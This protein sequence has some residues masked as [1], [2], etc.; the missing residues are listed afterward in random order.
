MAM[1]TNFTIHPT[2]S[3]K[4]A[5]LRLDKNKHGIILIISKSSKLIGVATDG[6]IRRKLVSDCKISDAIKN[7]MNTDFVSVNLTT[8]RESVIKKFD[9]NIKVIPV[10]NSKGILQKIYTLNDFPVA[11]EKSNYSRAKAPVRISFGGGGSD[12]THFFAKQKGAVINATVSLYSHAILKKRNDKKV[13][14]SSADLNSE[15][16]ASNIKAVLKIKTDLSLIQ[17]I[18][19]LIHPDFGFELQIYSDFPHSSGLG[20]SSAVSAAILGCFNEFKAD[21]WSDYEMAEIAYQAERLSLQISG[22]WQDQYACTFG[23]FNFMEFTLDDNLVHPLRLTNK[24]KLELEQ[25]LVLCNTGISHNSGNIHDDQKIS[26]SDK[27]IHDLVKLNVENT[28][29]IKNKIL[30]GNLDDFAKLL[31]TAWQFKRRFSSKISNKKLDNIYSGAKKN[32][33]V[34]GKLLGAGGGGFFIFYVKPFFRSKLVK[35]LKSK[36]LDVVNFSFDENGLQSWKFRE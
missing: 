15:I 22:G 27:K 9:N 20:G 6:D 21:P 7:C 3:I 30:K 33:A 26:M 31:D 2:S 28:H 16:K 34:G 17:S 10:L 11:P 14:I 29:K 12:L 5:L 24:T 13:I 32:G 23:G 36:N 8:P 19:K 18:I 35:Y 25:S 1:L 4:Q